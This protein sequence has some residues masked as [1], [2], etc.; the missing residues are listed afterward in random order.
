MCASCYT[1]DWQ[2]RNPGR[3]GND[4]L[5]N[6]PERA[7]VLRRKGSLKAKYG[8]T[9]EEYHALWL[10]QDGKCANPACDFTAES[11]LENYRM[12]L[13]ID[14]SHA[15]GKIRGLL[16]TNCNIAIGHALDDVNR[17]LGLIQ[18]LESPA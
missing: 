18:Y 5:K 10:A 11:V 1:L 17:L 9:P 4:W 2:K 6:N 13:K 8:I 14:H 16:C 15:T 12:G 3:S 7:R